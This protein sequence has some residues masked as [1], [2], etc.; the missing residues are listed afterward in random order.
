MST[1]ASRHKFDLALKPRHS[2]F[3]N[4]AT[5]LLIREIARDSEL[6]MRLVFIWA[7]IRARTRNRVKTRI[8]RRARFSRLGQQC[9]GS[10]QRGS[11][12]SATG[13]A[14]QPGTVRYL[15]TTLHSQSAS[16]ISKP[17]P[18]AFMCA[19]YEITLQPDQLPP[20]VIY[21][22]EANIQEGR[23]ILLK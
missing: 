4:G 11:L 19:L 1:R 9:I 6:A 16:I 12:L 20:R 15:G 14:M 2:P 18:Y 10:E 23:I 21:P 5:L 8:K 17:Q 7:Q 22:R 13:T 3:Q